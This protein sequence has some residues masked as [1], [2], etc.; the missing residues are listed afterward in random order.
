MSKS[1]YPTESKAIVL[2]LTAQPE[3]A[4]KVIREFSKKLGPIE[5]QSPWHPFHSHYYNEEVGENPQ[6][7]L[8]GFQN[9]FRPEQLPELKNL[10]R[11]LEG[12][13]RAINIDPGYV[14][15]FKVVLVSGKGGGMKVALANNAH[16]YT[17]LRYEHNQWHPF[18][19]TYPDFK[20][21]TYHEELFKLRR[22]L[23]K[24]IAE[25]PS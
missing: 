18:P 8:I 12:K 21:A 22:S 7:C 20:E 23:S 19:W 1:I 24:L 3:L 14:D 16:A 11:K 13:T 15:L 6:R 17:L 4:T 25:N 5:I 2:L 10:A 9:I